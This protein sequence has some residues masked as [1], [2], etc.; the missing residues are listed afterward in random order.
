M[1]HALTRYCKKD[2]VASPNTAGTHLLAQFS[3]KLQEEQII[4][5]AKLAGVPLL[6]TRGHYAG[7]PKG[8]EFI[9]AFATLGAEQ[10]DDIFRRF[11]DLLKQPQVT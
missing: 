1:L 11:A 9:I 10:I 8:N 6:S 7:T 2:V 3:E 4:A 5:C